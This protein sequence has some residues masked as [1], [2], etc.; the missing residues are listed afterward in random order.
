M[1][2][3]SFK[4]SGLE[5]A[6]RSRHFDPLIA[7]PH[8]WRNDGRSFNNAAIDKTKPVASMKYSAWINKP[9]AGRPPSNPRLTKRPTMRPPNTI[10]LTRRVARLDTLRKIASRFVIHAARKNPP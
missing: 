5:K 8:C 2:A 7:L 1:Y 9:Y 6:V 10:E 3:F 4:R